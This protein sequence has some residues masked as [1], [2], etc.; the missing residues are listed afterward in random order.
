MPVG[1]DERVVEPAPPPGESESVAI[2]T[3]ATPGT[4]WLL[5]AVEAV[6][7]A[8]AVPLPEVEPE[9]DDTPSTLVSDPEAMAVGTEWAAEPEAEAE[10][11][12][13]AAAELV[14]GA[15]TLPAP[16]PTVAPFPALKVGPA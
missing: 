9:D 10:A 16:A 5:E 13:E 15:G 14:V 6:A 12:P 11:L 4:L 2:K 1:I 7:V 8:D 3:G